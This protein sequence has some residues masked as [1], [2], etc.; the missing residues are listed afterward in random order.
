M[1]QVGP[2]VEL[3]N[4]WLNTLRGI[5]YVA[6]VTTAKLHLGFPGADG[7][8]VPFTVNT[9]L[10]FLF[11]EADNGEI[12]LIG[13][14]PVWSITAG[15][16]LTYISVWDGFD[17]SSNYL[18]PGLLKPPRQVADGDQFN[19]GTCRLVIPGLAA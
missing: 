5:P 8:L 11:S 17:D 19:L 10:S 18:F 1:A 12:A 3:A 2:S 6:S 13:A 7:T 16:L 15:G 14:P 9:R 4:S